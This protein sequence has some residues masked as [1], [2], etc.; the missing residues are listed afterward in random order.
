[1]STRAAAAFLIGAL[2]GLLLCA[3]LGRPRAD[4]VD[5]TIA[6]LLNGHADPR[7]GQLHTVVPV[8]ESLSLL[9]TV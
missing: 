7:D 3:P 1:M 2:S 5:T 6:T 4:T 9:A 8:Y